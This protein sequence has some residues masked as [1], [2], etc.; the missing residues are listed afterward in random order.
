VGSAGFGDARGCPGFNSRGRSGAQLG[1]AGGEGQRGGLGDS[2][3][4]AAC[5]GR[6][7]RTTAACRGAATA[8]TPSDD[9]QPR[10]ACADLGR[11]FNSARAVST[12]RLSGSDLGRC[13]PGPTTAAGARPILGPTGSRRAGSA[14]GPHLGLARA[15]AFAVGATSTAVMG[16]P[17]ARSPTPARGTV[18]GQ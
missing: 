17:Q 16:C 4:A 12:H 11:A 3:R 6:A 15:R 14:A 9:P 5:L 2:G 1:P 7:R 10:S 13:S 18:V 8:T